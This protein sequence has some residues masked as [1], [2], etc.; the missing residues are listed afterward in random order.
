MALPT[1][2]NQTMTFLD[3]DFLLRNET[4]RYLYH[5]HAARMPIIDYHNH[6]PPDEIASDKQFRTITEVWLKGDHYKWRAMRANGV[7]ET[8]ITGTASDAKKFEQWARTVPY[9]MRNPLYHWTHLELRRYFGMGTLLSEANAMEVYHQANEHLQQPDFSARGL[10]QQ[11]N[12]E[13]VCT[14]DDPVDD[15]RHHRALAKTDF[16]I[17][18]LPAFRPDRAILIGRSDFVAYLQ[19]LGE[20]ASQ[21]ISSFSQLMEALRN[22]IIFFHANGCRLA[23]HGLERMSAT[24]YDVQSVDRILQSRL[25]GKQVSASE[26]ESYQSAVLHQL[27]LLYHEFGWT[28][29]FHLGALRNNN[30]RLQALLGADVGADSIGDFQQARPLSNYL[31]RLDREHRLTQTI[32]YNL[33]PADNEVFATMVG[34]YNDGSRAG[35]MQWGSAWWFLDQKDGMEKQ[36]DTLSNMGLLSQFV[37]MLTDSRSFLSFPRHEYFRRILCN[38]FGTD[39]E[40]GDLPHD[41]P[42]L[43]QLVERICYHNAKGYFKF[44]EH[45]K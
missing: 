14:T 42:W 16:E 44:S 13:L 38:Q 30:D 22:R 21:E 36:I 43:G 18:M 12:V 28:M 4:A 27:G 34:N 24:D 3:Q 41:L 19:Q 23:D 32:L 9:T 31:N 40:N 15:L 2:P 7:P 8:D 20:A 6:L 25:A 33:N 45:A 39:V 1:T 35:K 37:G 26:A 29:Q 17:T 10:L 5:E 11:M